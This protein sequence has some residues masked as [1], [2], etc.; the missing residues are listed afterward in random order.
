[1]TMNKLTIKDTGW[2]SFTRF[3]R[4]VA[5]VEKEHKAAAPFDHYYIMTRGMLRQMR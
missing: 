3:N 4:F 1:M 5:V 2:A